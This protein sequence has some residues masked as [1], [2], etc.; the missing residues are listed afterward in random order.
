MT[1]CAGVV[2]LSIS[3][4]LGAFVLKGATYLDDS[5]D[6]GRDLDDAAQL[7]CAV[8]DPV[9]D[10][11]RMIRNGRKRIAALRRDAR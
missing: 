7:A 4:V 11:A 6:S 5:R 3:D 1:T 2:A 10:R 9:G 8:T